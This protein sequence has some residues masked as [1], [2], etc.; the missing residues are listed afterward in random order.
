MSLLMKVPRRRHRPPRSCIQL[1]AS[2][3]RTFP[4]WQES[5]GRTAADKSAISA[6]EG[7]IARRLALS[8]AQCAHDESAEPWTAHSEG[9]SRPSSTECHSGFDGLLS[10][11]RTVLVAHTAHIAYRRSEHQCTTTLDA[12]THDHWL[13]LDQSRGSAVANGR[14][15]SDRIPSQRPVAR[16]TVGLSATT[17]GQAG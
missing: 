4:L 7:E 1:V 2:R 11:P 13:Q 17:V 5:C 16:S 6:E 14:G 10:A 15:E 9:G 12:A 8:R 3:L